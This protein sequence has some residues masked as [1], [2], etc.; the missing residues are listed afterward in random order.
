[1]KISAG[2]KTNF[3]DQYVYMLDEMQNLGLVVTISIANT[4][5][6]KGL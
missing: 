5:N 2:G 1:M 6:M 4:T 3:F